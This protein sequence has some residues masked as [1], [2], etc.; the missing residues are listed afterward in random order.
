MKI[1]VT[2]HR[3]NRLKNQQDNIRQWLFLQ[4]DKHKCTEAISGMAQGA[5]QIFAQVAVEKDI[6]LICCY[7]YRKNFFHQEEQKILS[8]Y[9]VRQKTSSLFQKYILV[10]EFTGSETSTW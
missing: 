6:P 9:S 10:T 2:G 3:P 8:K 4:L 1:A 5:D 7:P